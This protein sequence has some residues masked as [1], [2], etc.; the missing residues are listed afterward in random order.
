MG[1]VGDGEGG[2][3]GY[4]LGQDPENGCGVWKLEE[5]G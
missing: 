4:T 3:E 5:G 2:V 1:W